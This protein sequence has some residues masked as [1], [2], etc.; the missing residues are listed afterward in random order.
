MNRL[1]LYLLLVAL[2]AS[3]VL[4]PVVMSAQDAGKTVFKQGQIDEDIYVAGGRVDVL[5]EVS[6][7]V[8]AAG[9]RVAID[10][11]VTG[12][13][14]AAGGSVTVHGRIDDDVRLAGGE[15]TLSATVGDGVVV[16]GGNVLLAPAATVA[17][18]AMF[19][20]GRV[21][22]AGRVQGDVQAAGGRI[23]ISGQTGGDVELTGRSIKVRQDAVILGNLTYRSPMPA[24]IDSGARI[25]GSI[26][27]IAMPMPGSMEILRGILAVGLL[28]WLG[29]ALAGVV[30]YLLFPQEVISMARAIAVGPWPRLGLGL[31]VFAASPLVSL[32]LLSTAVGWLLAWI[33]ITIYAL[34]L[35]F[36]FL[37]GV[38]F[39]SDAVLRRFRPSRPSSKLGN[40]LMFVLTLLLVSIIGLIPLLGWLLVFL[41]L[42]LGTGSIILE[43]YQARQPV[44][45]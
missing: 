36:G 23:V 33:L 28:L 1:A 29:F 20:G 42:L 7:D 40:C 25:E 39:L 12:D 4:A 5:A 37:I 22:L 6:G 41:L 43:L 8:I 21:E 27:Y 35:I 2:L 31:A 3:L 38:L 9:G 32:L 45:A 10:S 11:Q 18:D 16:A 24:D 44:D 17:G 13:V 15:V 14:M 26:S 34:L 19:S 30:L